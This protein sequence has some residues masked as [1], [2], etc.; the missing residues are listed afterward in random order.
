MGRQPVDAVVTTTFVGRSAELR[1]LADIADKVVAG[2]PQV[3]WVRGRAGMGKTSLVRHFVS[4]LAEF[5]VLWATADGSES[6]LEYGVIDQLVHRLPPDARQWTSLLD[7]VAGAEANPLAV[8]AQLL[9]LL[10]TLQRGHSVMIVVDDVQW[11]D[12]NSISALSF[13]LRRIWVDQVLVV[14]VARPVHDLQSG[15]IV[16]RLTHSAPHAAT[17]DLAG[18]GSADVAGLSSLVVGKDLPGWAV[19]RLWRYTR[20]HPLLLRTLL[21][22]V[23]SAE[24]VDRSRSLT[25]PRSMVAAVNA[26][27]RQLPVSTRGLL[28]ALAVLGTRS[29]LA[30]VARISGIEHPT[31]ALQPALD[32][33][34]MLWWPDDPVS[35]IALAHDLH[36]EAIY[37]ALTPVRRRE[38]HARAAAV[39]DQGTA[40]AHRVA[41]STSTD[42]RLAGDLEK[43]AAAE[44]GSGRHG[45]AAAYLR[46]AADLSG[47]PSEYERRLL[48]SGVHALFS[49]DRTEAIR[50]R[51][52]S[53]S[54]TPSALRSLFLG[55]TALWIDGDW[56]TSQRLLVEAVNQSGSA[57]TARWVRSA[58]S[59]G[60]AASQVWGDDSAAAERAALAA[61]AIGG[62]PTLLLDYTRVLLAVV[63]SRMHG[64]VA[65]RATLTGLPANPSLVSTV[66]LD[67]LACRGAMDTLLGRFE[68][69]KR[70]LG[71]VVRRHRAGT[72]LIGG[73]QPYAYLAASH[74]QLGEWDD[75]TIVIEQ[76][77]AS[78]ADADEPPQ[79]RTVRRLVASLVPSGRGD[80]PTALRHVQL[81]RELAAQ[82]GGAQDLRYAALAHATMQHAK[83]DRA[84]LLEALR[85]VPGLS[86]DENGESNNT[87]WELW[88]RPLLIEGLLHR[89]A[90]DVAGH[91]LALLRKATSE[92]PYLMP[93]VV[94]LSAAL[95][96]RLDDAQGALAMATT[97]LEQRPPARLPLAEG[98]LEHE[99]GRRLLAG[100]RR[101]EAIEWL[102][103]A[104]QCF[105]RLGAAPYEQR[106]DDDLRLCGVRSAR[107]PALLAGLTGREAEVVHLVERHLTNR[108]IGGQLFVTA[109]TVEYHLG[110]I[111][112]KLGVN[113]RRELRELLAARRE[114]NPRT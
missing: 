22:D 51:A 35:P 63:T 8:G 108:E 102:R 10:G 96:S 7:S 37:S 34:L 12:A 45:V 107:S 78:A 114:N 16:E 33:G 27:M 21:A 19:E 88:L 70:D 113:S 92:A 74:Y 31:E 103:S 66:N 91:H 50:V 43:A 40:W 82:V 49:A 112:G 98:L 4:T 56:S 57:P 54:I 62:L 73:S 94:R 24:L 60:L 46:W 39:V 55:L 111:Y 86:D 65:G 76:A 3:V 59:A 48:T 83:G 28:D 44:A 77:L 105:A 30:R 99:H 79:N 53:P 69:A 85:D 42:S 14:L 2:S 68:S 64:I 23:P 18:L 87:W 75:A 32:A 20:G 38:L 29:P 61:L 106:V 104:K 6:L 47:T 11:A 36:R 81:A 17:I 101:A 97:Y 110:N 1:R 15:K 100:D 89:G 90:T 84:G 52:C 80:W 25:A 109:K 13:L 93:T 9:D 26:S 41:A 72:Y 95:A 5:T 67:A 58:A 71:D